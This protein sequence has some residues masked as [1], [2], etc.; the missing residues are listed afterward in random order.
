MRLQGTRRKSAILLNRAS[1]TLFGRHHWL[2]EATR[3][4][5][6]AGLV[7]VGGLA[8]LLQEDHGG[9]LVFTYYDAAYRQS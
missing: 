7:N 2:E 1:G 5:R 4:L 6:S 8:Y 3:R 9:A